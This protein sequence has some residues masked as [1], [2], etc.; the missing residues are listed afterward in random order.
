[1][2]IYEVID[3]AY[4]KES[5]ILSDDFMQHC[6]D[7]ANEAQF[8]PLE[9]KNKIK[10]MEMEQRLYAQVVKLRLKDLKFISADKN[11]NEATFKFEGISVRSQS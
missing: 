7:N 2:P 3:E 8:I 1:M 6:K 5:K 9:T 10:Q 4:F 11:K